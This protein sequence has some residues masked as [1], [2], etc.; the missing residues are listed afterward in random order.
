MISC[1]VTGHRRV[2]D[3]MFQDLEDTYTNSSLSSQTALLHTGTY[4]LFRMPDSYSYV[5][6]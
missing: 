6:Y 2:S 5:N 4:S 1:V 3:L